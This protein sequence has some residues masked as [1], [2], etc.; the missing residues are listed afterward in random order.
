MICWNRDHHLSEFSPFSSLACA[1][2]PNIP[3]T[4]ASH[5]LREKRKA[6]TVY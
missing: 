5:H 2:H 1:A 6:M 4:C 3:Q